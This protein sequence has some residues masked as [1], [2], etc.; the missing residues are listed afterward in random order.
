MCY[1]FPLDFSTEEPARKLLCF[2]NVQIFCTFQW[3]LMKITVCIMNMGIKHVYSIYVKC[4]FS[5]LP[6]L[7]LCIKHICLYSWYNKPQNAYPH[8]TPNYNYGTDTVST[9]SS[10]FLHITCHSDYLQR[11]NVTCQLCYSVI[12]CMETCHFMFFR[13]LY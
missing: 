8:T 5:V 13:T 4:F 12:I 10:C 2:F 9:P 3:I 6:L 1:H 7:M 11:K